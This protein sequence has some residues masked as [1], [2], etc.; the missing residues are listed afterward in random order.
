MSP[1]SCRRRFASCPLVTGCLIV[2]R[3]QRATR[4]VALHVRELEVE[5]IV[6]YG[7]TRF[8]ATGKSS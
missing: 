6:Q 3:H 1:C 4:V 7:L 8:E 5:G 2:M